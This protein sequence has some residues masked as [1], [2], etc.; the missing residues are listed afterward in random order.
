MTTEKS[1]NETVDDIVADM[2]LPRF[3]A[4]TAMRANNYHEIKS[5]VANY[6]DRIKAAHKREV[7]K[8]TDELNEAK[9]YWKLW[10]ARSD[11]LLKMC[12][13]N[14]AIAGHLKDLVRRFCDYGTDNI[15]EEAR[16]HLAELEENS[17]NK[18]KGANNE[19]HD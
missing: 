6:R 9:Q 18:K 15:Y 14:Y 13:K 5:L 7:D 17:D 19:S 3:D 16:A 10:S 1:D 2:L 11:E 4:I 8:L 12:D